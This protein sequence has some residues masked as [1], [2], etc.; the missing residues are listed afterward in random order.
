MDTV[1]VVAGLSNLGKTLDEVHV[2]RPEKFAKISGIQLG[3]RIS[4]DSLKYFL[5]HEDGG[6]K[7]IPPGVRR[8]LLLNQADRVES[9]SEIMRIANYC[10]EEFNIVLIGSIGLESPEPS[11]NARVENSAGIILAG[12]GST[13]MRGMS[14]PMLDFMGKSLLERAINTA[15]SAG[16]APIIVVTG[17]Q[18]DLVTESIR[19]MDI[20]VVENLKWENGQSTSIQAGLSQL[21]DRCGAAVFMLVDQPFV[22]VELIQKLVDEHQ[23]NLVPI[24]APMVDDRRAN[25]VLFDRM[26]FAELMT[27]TGDTGGRAVMGHYNHVW[28]PWLDKRLLLDI[29]TQADLEAC[30]GAT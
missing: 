27:L 16:L 24:I 28:V 10:K 18:S 9:T 6:L 3:D 23:T 14:K 4:P 19:Q 29:D 11:I 22:S 21:G 7:R 17:Y 13:R 30:I 5:C 26:T 2:F 20:E 8:I 1:I 15:Q 12:G 25:P